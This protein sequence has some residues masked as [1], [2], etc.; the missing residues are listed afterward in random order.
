MPGKS[1]RAALNTA[2]PN[3]LPILCDQIDFGEALA[4]LKRTVRGTVVGN[5]LVL[6]EDA[7]AGTLLKVY[8]AG[9]VSGYK[10]ILGNGSNAAPAT[11]ECRIT[12]AGNVLFNSGTDVITQAVVEYLAVEG[13]G[14]ELYEETID[15][16]SNVGT[17]L[18]Q[19]A[20]LLLLGATSLTGTLT[21]ALAPVNRGNTPATTFAAIG[22][23]VDGDKT[24]VFATA[25]AVTRATVRY[26]ALPG[27][28][29]TKRVSAGDALRQD[30]NCV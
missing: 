14:Y 25:D 30:A 22:A 2:N 29:V 12:G 9:T 28:G 15:V 26:I 17:L 20:A 19:R 11:T 18:G 1:V 13:S 5:T 16:T 21:G 10:T 6:P 7:K 4:L 24:I 27:V 8:G 3:S 23:G